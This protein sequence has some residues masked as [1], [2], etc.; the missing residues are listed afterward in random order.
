GWQGAAQPYAIARGV[1]PT[2]VHASAEPG[3]LR[4]R[5]AVNRCGRGGRSEGR[6]R[7][8]PQC[9]QRTLRGERL[10]PSA[11]RVVRRGRGA[12]HK[13]VVAESGELGVE[14]RLLRGEAEPD[15]PGDRAKQAGEQETGGGA[16][17]LFPPARPRLTPQVGGE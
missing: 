4:P 9:E 1:R 14:R 2:R 12:H 13:R 8:L 6:D 5:R 7:P 10:R 17:R 15:E 16:P 11:G 3:E